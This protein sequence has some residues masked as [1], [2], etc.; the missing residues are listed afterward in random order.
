MGIGAKNVGSARIF[1]LRRY[2]TLMYSALQARHSQTIVL[3]VCNANTVAL[4]SRS[5]W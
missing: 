2:L 1:A 3:D 5:V 4:I